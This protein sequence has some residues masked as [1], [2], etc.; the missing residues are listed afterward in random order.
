MS[1]MSYIQLSRLDAM[2]YNKLVQYIVLLPM[3]I[4]IIFQQSAI[5]KTITVENTGLGIETRNS[6]ILYTL[7]IDRL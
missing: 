7:L 1:N 6:A 3:N 5:L 4:S 2:Y